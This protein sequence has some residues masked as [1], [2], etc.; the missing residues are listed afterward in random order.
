M[1]WVDLEVQNRSEDGSVLLAGKTE[2][3]REAERL[4]RPAPKLKPPRH[5]KRRERIQESDPDTD[6]KD[7]DLSQN[8]K[9]IGGSVARRF[10][11]SRVVVGVEW[12]T[13]ESRKKYLKDHPKADPAKHTVKEEDE[14]AKEEPEAQQFGG[15]GGAEEEAEGKALDEEEK[16]QIKKNKAQFKEWGWGKEENKAYKDLG[17]SPTNDNPEKYKDLVEVL[18]G[19]V[20]LGGDVSLKGILQTSGPELQKKIKAL[21]KQNFTS[22]SEP[23]PDKPGVETQKL[24]HKSK[25]PKREKSKKPAES[26]A[27]QVSPEEIEEVGASTLEEAFPEQSQPAAEE[28]A[29]EGEAPAEEPAPEAKKPAPKKPSGKK[30]TSEKTEGG[31]PKKPGVKEEEAAKAAAEKET[32]SFVKAKKHQ[33]PAFQKFLSSLPSAEEVDHRGEPSTVVEDPTEPGWKGG[34]ENMSSAGQKQLIDQYTEGAKKQVEGWTTSGKHRR[35][36]FQQF[37]DAIPTS[38][39]DPETGEVLVLDH[40]TKKKIP[41]EKLNSIAQKSLLDTYTEQQQ[42][43]S[44]ESPKRLKRLAESLGSV[45][46]PDAQKVI[47]SL[48]DPNGKATE[49]LGQLEEAGHDLEDIRADKVF[50]ALKGQLPPGIETAAQFKAAVAAKSAW[51][52]TPMQKRFDIPDPVRSEPSDADRR[53]ALDQIVEAFPAKI[54]ARIIAS[55]PHPDDVRT[56]IDTYQAARNAPVKSVGDLVRMASDIYQT[57]PE[58][59][60]PPKVGVNQAGEEVPWEAMSPEEQGHAYKSHQMQVLA[61]SMAAEHQVQTSLRKNL[62]A[63]MGPVAAEMANAL[64][65]KKPVDASEVFNRSIVDRGHV[66]IE[67]KQIAATL[68]A[69]DGSPEAQKLAIA[70]FQANDYQ[71]ARNRFGSKAVRA[72]MGEDVDDDEEDSYRFEQISENDSPHAIVGGLMDMQ[73]F[74]DKRTSRYPKELVEQDPAGIFKKQV[75]SRVAEL[76]PDKFPKVRQGLAPME[77]KAYDKKV[78]AWEKEHSRWS[79]DSGLPEPKKPVKPDF[80]DLLGSAKGEGSQRES[81]WK[82][83]SRRMG[84]GKAAA[85]VAAQHEKSFYLSA[86]STPMSRDKSAVYNGVEPLPVPPYPGWQQAHQRDLGDSDWELILTAAKSWLKNPVLAAPVTDA[87]RDTQLRAAL[88]LAIQ[89]SPYQAQIQPPSYNML[90]ARLAGKDDPMFSGLTFRAAVQNAM[91]A[92]DTFPKGAV[93]TMKASHEIRKFAAQ[94]AETNPTLAYDLV[95]LATRLAAQEDDDKDDKKSNQQ[96]EKKEN[97]QEQK[98]EASDKFSQLRALVI[99]TAASN[100]AARPALL[101]VLQAIKAMA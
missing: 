43:A 93:V 50:P 71:E 74:F 99:K 21:I 78:E 96:Q 32:K 84:F 75:L 40:D 26:E 67:D 2:E 1:T 42:Q 16:E 98:K 54:A 81:F 29:P 57:D 83:L 60:T 46:S 35:K 97:Q 51:D 36:G 63:E 5:D 70:A 73:R 69:L 17:I 49:V 91:K 87:T 72:A 23:S 7:K 33:Q 25:A 47:G 9:D 52:S 30:P 76:A 59:I 55:N 15:Y 58:R 62:P 66:P 38:D 18:S 8:Y 11:A 41:F 90:L 61:M 44:S 80:Y 64:L 4:V 10:L 95:E 86:F 22:V 79:E 45:K 56:L 65:R 6:E 88:D 77:A 14:S 53:M 13:E 34:F 31:K 89:Q 27:E 12:P 48:M 20:E 100:P 82:T 68:K 94:A 3:E 28:P 24:V 85:K 19:K 92:E 101:P 37:L 39:T